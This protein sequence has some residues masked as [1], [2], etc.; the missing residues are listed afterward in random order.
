VGVYMCI[1]VKKVDFFAY[2]KKRVMRDEAPSV[3]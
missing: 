3:T 2:A 1:E